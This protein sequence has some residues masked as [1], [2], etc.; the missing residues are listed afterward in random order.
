[1]LLTRGLFRAL[2]LAA[3][4]GCVYVPLGKVPKLSVANLA[5]G[6]GAVEVTAKIVSGGFSTPDGLSI[7]ALVEPFSRTD[8][9]NLILKVYR[10]TG[11]TETPVLALSGGGTQ[12]QLALANADLTKP[13][14]FR[15]LATFTIYRVRAYAYRTEGEDKADLLNDVEK[16]TIEFRTSREESTV[17]AELPVQLIP[18]LFA[19]QGASPLAVKP[20]SVKNK[21]TEVIE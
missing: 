14:R 6:S 21:G 20:G 3:C 2:A 13:V 8:I 1:M 15:N 16:S 18:K 4:A 11:D 17:T 7:Q 5:N 9:K 10:V 12:L 19:G